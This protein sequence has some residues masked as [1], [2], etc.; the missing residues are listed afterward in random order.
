[1]LNI[2]SNRELFVDDYLIDIAATSAEFTIHHPVRRE[3]VLSHD[4]PYEG[5]CSNYHNILHDGDLYRMYYL[6]WEFGREGLVV[7]YAESRDG[8]HFVKPELGICEFNGSTANNII[9]DAKA[10]GVGSGMEA[11]GIDNFM[12][13]RDDNPACDPS[14][15]Y[16]AIAR[17][18]HLVE[19]KHCLV[20]RAYY[21][22]DAIHFTPGDIIAENG[23]FDSLNVAFWDETVQKYRCY[24]LHF[25]HCGETSGMIDLDSVNFYSDVRDIR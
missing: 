20:L 23:A 19:G 21:S 3:S 22:Q 5:D 24:F 14:K 10:H 6:G 15:R 2:Q 8:I 1:M 4:A 9:L 18:D 13:F 11:S 17:W 16:K 12:V 25:N 7:C